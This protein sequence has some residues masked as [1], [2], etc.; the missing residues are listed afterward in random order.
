MGWTHTDASGREIIRDGEATEIGSPDTGASYFARDG[1]VYAKRLDGA[2]EEAGTALSANGRELD[3]HQAALSNAQH[4]NATIE[5]HWLEYP[6][7]IP[8]EAWGRDHLSTLLYAESRAVDHGG[9]LPETDPHMRTSRAYPTRLGNGVE[10]H[11]HTDY[12]CL[13]DAAAAGFLTYEN[14]IVRFTDDGWT[15]VHG[16]RRSRAERALKKTTANEGVLS[17]AEYAAKSA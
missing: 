9:K 1:K 2:V 10:V 8:V 4:A 13:T 5:K 7:G 17:A 12:D 16:L 11:G 15:F 6:D 14:G 3:R